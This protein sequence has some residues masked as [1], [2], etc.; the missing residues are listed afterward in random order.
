MQR[1]WL[2]VLIVIVSVLAACSDD[3][4]TSSDGNATSTPDTVSAAPSAPTEDEVADSA[5]DM[6]DDLADDLEEQQAA[7][8]GGSAT[9]V[10]GD[11]QWTFQSV[12]CAIGE[13]Q[14]GQAGAEFVLSSIQDGLQ[15]YASIDSFGHSV[16]LNDIQDFENPSVAISWLGQSGINVAGKEV[17]AEVE[18]IDETSDDF[19]TVAGTIMATCR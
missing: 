10:V 11:Q 17:T 5:Q 7:Q 14:T 6:A 19:E 13:E 3:N 4:G 2:T 8:G 18:M 1:R 9:L 15:M 12:L 16:S